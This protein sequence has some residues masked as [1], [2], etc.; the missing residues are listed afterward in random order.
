M[1][2]SVVERAVRRMG[3][4]ARGLHPFPSKMARAGEIFREAAAPLERQGDGEGLAGLRM[5]MGRAMQEM[6][7]GEIRNV[8]GAMGLSAAQRMQHLQN[9]M[10]AVEGAAWLGE[11][12]LLRLRVDL[13]MAGDSLKGDRP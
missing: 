5:A 13:S 3:E 1:E 10:E 7:M 6:V 11:Q 9:M 12:V 2:P 8:K 4:V